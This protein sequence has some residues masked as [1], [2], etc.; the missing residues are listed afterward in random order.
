RNVRRALILVA[1]GS[2]AAAVIT[3]VST[4]DL[5]D[6]FGSSDSSQNSVADDSP[7]DSGSAEGAAFGD[8]S[9]GTCLSWDDPDNPKVEEVDC[10]EPHYFEV[11]A[12]VNLADFP[13]AEFGPHAQVTDAQ[14]Y[15]QIRDTVCAPAV[16]RYLDGR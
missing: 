7:R 3:L 10:A 2:I 6:V 9:A 15:S 4:G 14:R 13:S 11:G 1:L 8:A 5:D 12:R 16:A